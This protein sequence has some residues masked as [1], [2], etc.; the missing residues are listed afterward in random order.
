MKVLIIEDEEAA[1]RR[2]HKLLQELDPGIEVVGELD[3]ISQSVRWLSKNPL[4]DLLLLDIHLADGASFE[5]FQ[6]IKIDCPVVFITAYD[7]YAIEAFQHNAVDY[8]LKPIKRPDLER[9]IAKYRR[10]NQAPAVD[11]QKLAQVLQREPSQR[12]FLI[13]V[14]QNIR[15]IDLREVAY[16]YS[17]E[18]ITFLMTQ[19]GKRYPIDYS[20]DRLEELVDPARFF[21]I[22]RQFIISIDAIREM[23]AYS[24]SR[25]KIELS[26]D[27]ESDTIVSTERSPHFKKWLT[28]EEM[29]GE[30]F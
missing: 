28:G 15:L 30:E 9:A 17:E 7:Q 27:I 3:S 1:A 26:P 21:R 6:Q 4:P 23:H 14:G 11:Y 19:D 12:R 13:R 10:W 20:L 2:L 16:F 29:S 24:K 18:K 22:N 5:I 8:L 25:V